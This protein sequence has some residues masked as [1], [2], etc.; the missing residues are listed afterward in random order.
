MKNVKYIAS[1]MLVTC[2]L[3]LVFIKECSNHYHDLI[4]EQNMWID[5]Y[6][7]TKPIACMTMVPPQKKLESTSSSSSPSSS[8]SPSFHSSLASWLMLP[9]FDPIIDN[10][11]ELKG[12]QWYDQKRKWYWG[13]N[14]Q[15]RCIHYYTMTKT[16]VLSRFSV[17]DVFLKMLLK[18]TV[19]VKNCIVS[20]FQPLH[21]VMGLV[22]TFKTILICVA[23]KLLLNILNLC[24]YIFKGFGTFESYPWRQKNKKIT[25]NEGDNEEDSGEDAEEE[26]NE[27]KRRSIV[28]RDDSLGSHHVTCIKPTYIKPIIRYE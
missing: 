13:L 8:P 12:N 5:Y 7:N 14:E 25:T 4:L 18:C 15:E 22:S 20:I 10:N 28:V 1:S 27:K 23:T 21:E 3:L 24:R 26:E 6:N 17:F 2:C 11:N 16:D 9:F 19:Y